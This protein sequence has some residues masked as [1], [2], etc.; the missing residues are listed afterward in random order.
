M[1]ANT[2][3]PAGTPMGQYISFTDTFEVSPSASGDCS[4]ILSGGT[5]DSSIW[6]G[7]CNV[8]IVLTYLS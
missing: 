6:A 1:T 2:I 3:D 7:T 8:S 4:L 5:F